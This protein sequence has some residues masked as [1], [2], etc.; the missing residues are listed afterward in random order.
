MSEFIEN[1]EKIK[2]I[3]INENN[4]KKLFDISIN[5]EGL[6]RHASTHAAG[7]VISDNN[8]NE[9]VPL[10]K[11]PK[12]DVPVT[13]FSMKYVEKAGLIKFDFLGLK[14][15]TVIDETIQCLRKKNI[16]LDIDNILLNDKKT[17]D[18]LKSGNTTGIFQLEGQWYETLRRISYQI[19]L[20]I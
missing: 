19:D 5:L 4:I 6:L 16:Y 7:I 18:I 17:F 2:K 20:K 9:S 13:Q 12:S 3:I 15:L 14:T 11:D 10:Y 8:L 1:D